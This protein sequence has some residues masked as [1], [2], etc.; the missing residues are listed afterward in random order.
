MTP[1]QR[2]SL[3][4]QVEG[5][6]GE[7][8]IADYHALLNAFEIDGH[9]TLGRSHAEERYVG[10]RSGVAG[11]GGHTAG[12]VDFESVHK[13]PLYRHGGTGLLGV[14]GSVV[15]LILPGKSVLFSTAARPSIAARRRG[16]PDGAAASSPGCRRARR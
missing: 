5:L 13:R 11:R 4:D 12:A 14:G 3:A 9:Q 15:C 16:V 10:K 6:L 8:D 2:E 1:E 7:I